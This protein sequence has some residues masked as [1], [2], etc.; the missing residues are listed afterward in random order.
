MDCPECGAPA[1]SCETRYHECLVIEF[2][3]PGYGAVHHLTVATY[4]LQHSSKL[5][6][7]GWLYERELLKEF[8]V[9]GKAPQLVRKQNHFRLDS[10]KRDFK[11]ASKDA[12]PKI[13][14]HQWMKTILD[15]RL[16]DPEVYCRDV[17]AWAEAVLQ[18][19]QTCQVLET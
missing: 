1:Q 19:A 5:T 14:R 11:I 4:M 10:G 17:T 16:D 13:A 3:E 12:L 7:E 9:E 18:D 8:V 15:I 6:K 2:S